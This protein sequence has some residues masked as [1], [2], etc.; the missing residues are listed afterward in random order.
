VRAIMI[1]EEFSDEGIEENPQAIIQ[2]MFAA[3]CTS[4]DAQRKLLVQASRITIAGGALARLT[5][6]WIMA[7]KIF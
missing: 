6:A 5:T 3:Y 7:A 4:V 1:G 2:R